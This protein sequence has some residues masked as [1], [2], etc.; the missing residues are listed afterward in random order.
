[1]AVLSQSWNYGR[2]GQD[3]RRWWPVVKQELGLLVC[4]VPLLQT[5]LRATFSPVVTCSDASH[6]G[7]A[8]AT[9]VSLTS[10]GG[11]LTRCLQDPGCAAVEVELLVVSAFNGIGGAFRGYDSAGV[12]PRGLVAIEWSKAAQRVTR[13][14][15]PRVIEVGDIETVTESTVKEW[16]NR[17]PESPCALGGRL[18]L[19]SPVSCPRWAAELKRGRIE[20]FL[21]LGGP[22]AMAPNHL[23]PHCAGGLYH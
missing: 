9:A 22:A 14:A 10:A 5:D 11:Q 7:G 18:P 15:W 16:S 23:W 4:L 19:C 8:V 6:F 21:E 2:K 12:K 20:A 13:K 1:M 3:R 17:S